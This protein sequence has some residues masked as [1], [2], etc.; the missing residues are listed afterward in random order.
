NSAQEPNGTGRP[1]PVADPAATTPTLAPSATSPTTQPSL[2]PNM[3][4]HLQKTPARKKSLPRSA[5]YTAPRPLSSQRGIHRAVAP[6]RTL[7]APPAVVELERS[8]RLA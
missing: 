1:A 2:L 7:G 8:Q 5:S 3:G 6:N 4:D